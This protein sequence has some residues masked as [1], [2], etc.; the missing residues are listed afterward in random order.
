[1]QSNMEFWHA[2]SRPPTT[3]LKPI[4]GGRLKGKT[5]INP[6]W[7]YQAMTEMF[8]PIGFGWKY[9]IDRLWT[10][11]GP[12][13]ERMAFAQV[14]VYVAHES[15][16][17][18]AIQGIGGAAMIAME[19]S[20]LV[21]SDEAYKMATTDALSVALKMLGVAAEIYLGNFDGSKYKTEAPAAEEPVHDKVIVAKFFGARTM[22]ELGAVWASLDQEQRRKYADVKDARKAELNQKADRD[23]FVGEMEAQ[24]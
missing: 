16:W 9:T 11:D 7:R 1:M 20:G 17:S 21:G 3:A 22:D 19:K 10:E 4:S 24:A 12:N 15:T 8:G 14:S 13:G 5:D 2:L 18:D 6:Q 23:A